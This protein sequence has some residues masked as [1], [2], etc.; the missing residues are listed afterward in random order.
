MDGDLKRVKAT[1]EGHCRCRQYAI[2]ML[3]IMGYIHSLWGNLWGRIVSVGE[4]GMGLSHLPSFLLMILLRAVGDVGSQAFPISEAVLITKFEAHVPLVPPQRWVKEQLCFSLGKPILTWQ[5]R[6]E[7]CTKFFWGPY[8]GDAETHPQ[9]FP[10]ARSP[11]HTVLWFDRFSC[12][13]PQLL[14]SERPKTVPWVP[15]STTQQSRSS[16]KSSGL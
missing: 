12:S 15:A 6:A 10:L 14:G 5:F 13:L 3:D 8:D 7:E 9:H 16:K 1:V 4:M 2:W 11:L